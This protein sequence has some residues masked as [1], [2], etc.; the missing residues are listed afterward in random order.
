MKDIA[1][2][3]RAEALFM[4]NEPVFSMNFK[5]VSSFLYGEQME[6]LLDNEM[7]RWILYLAENKK[8]PPGS[9]YH[10][11]MGKYIKN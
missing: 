9:E 10:R 5:A 1:N 2:I 3:T 8:L 6:N 4:M 11:F 7:H